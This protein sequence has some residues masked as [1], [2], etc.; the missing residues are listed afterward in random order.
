[1]RRIFVGDVQGCR[2]ELEMLLDELRFDSAADL[3]FLVGDVI[4]R[5]PE[6]L[7]TLRLLQSVH[8]EFVLGNHEAHLLDRGFFEQAHPEPEEWPSLGDLCALGHEER[9]AW[10]RYLREAPL[11]RVWPD[12]YL[13]H[14]ALP[15]ALWNPGVADEEIERWAALRW[16]SPAIDAEEKW[17]LTTTRYC[18]ADGTRSPADWPPPQ[19][20]YAPWDSF[21]HAE[22]RVVFGHWARRGL[23]QGPSVRG[24]DTGCV[25][26][27]SLTAWIAEEDRIVQVPATKAWIPT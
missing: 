19:E 3:L 24:L 10:G 14:A 18:D 25:Y 8:A 12:L 17:F 7:A 15:P 6:S 2:I 20:P 22:R 13:V 11:L 26:G 1:M 9:Q 4:R 16:D 21:Y 23:V 27:G 5:G